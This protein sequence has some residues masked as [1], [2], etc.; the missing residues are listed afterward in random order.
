MSL[1]AGRV[2]GAHLTS[3]Q[4]THTHYY[5]FSH[6]CLPPHPRWHCLPAAEQGRGVSAALSPCVILPVS[7]NWDF[8]GCL[9]FRPLAYIFPKLLIKYFNIIHKETGNWL[10]NQFPFS[11]VSN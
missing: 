6:L 3:R 1:D 4:L 9:F 5:C 7:Q 10:E 2:C 11:V 8:C